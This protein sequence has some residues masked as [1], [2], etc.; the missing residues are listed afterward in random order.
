MAWSMLLSDFQSG[1][2]WLTS[3][4]NSQASSDRQHSSPFSHI[5]CLSPVTLPRSHSTQAFG[6]TSFAVGVVSVSFC[7]DEVQPVSLHS[8]LLSHSFRQFRSIRLIRVGFVHLTGGNDDACIYCR[9][10]PDL[11]ML[12]HEDKTRFQPFMGFITLQCHCELREGALLY[13]V[14]KADLCGQKVSCEVICCRPIFY[15]L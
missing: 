14:A 3:S 12:F 10:R 8:R 15:L 2:P 6:V 5:S 13:P 1:L 4:L 11:C 9:T 7:V